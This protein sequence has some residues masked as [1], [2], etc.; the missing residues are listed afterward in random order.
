VTKDEKIRKFCLNV[1]AHSEADYEVTINGNGVNCSEAATT[2]EGL[3]KIMKLTIPQEE[4]VE[5][6]NKLRK[7]YGDYDET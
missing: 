5:E 6:A 3:M 2:V 1:L 7:Q 4:V